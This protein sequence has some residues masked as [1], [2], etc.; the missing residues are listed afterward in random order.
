MIFGPG[1][2]APASD[3]KTCLIAQSGDQ[4]IDRRRSGAQIVE[5]DQASNTDHPP[6]SGASLDYHAKPG[7]NRRPGGAYGAASTLMVRS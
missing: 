7:R 2:E 6:R 3:Q 1:A 5:D 4:L